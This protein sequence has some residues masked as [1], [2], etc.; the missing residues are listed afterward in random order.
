MI[1]EAPAYINTMINCFAL[2]AD[3]GGYELSSEKGYILVIPE[4]M[5]IACSGDPVV[6]TRCSIPV[7]G[8]SGIHHLSATDEKSHSDIYDLKGCIITYPVSGKMYVRDGK[9]FIYK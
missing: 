3:F 9:V 5:V 8:G 1:K 6:N 2:S 7:T 4:G